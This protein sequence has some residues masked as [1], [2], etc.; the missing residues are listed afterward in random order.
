[1]TTLL[2]TELSDDFIII[3]IANKVGTTISYILL[4][5]KETETG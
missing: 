1:M 4:I 5:R 2:D 3:T